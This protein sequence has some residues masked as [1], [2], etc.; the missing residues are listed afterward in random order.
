M[1]QATQ[2]LAERD[3][4]RREG[5]THLRQVLRPRDSDRGDE[6]RRAGQGGYA[7]PGDSVTGPSM[8]IQLNVKGAGPRPPPVRTRSKSCP[9]RDLDRSTTVVGDDF[10]HNLNVDET[11][12]YSFK[13][14]RK[15]RPERPD[16]GLLDPGRFTAKPVTPTCATD[17]SLC[18]KPSNKFVFKGVTLNKKKGTGRIKVK[19]P[20]LGKTTL[21]GPGLNT[22]KATVKKKGQVIGLNLKPK[23][24]SGRP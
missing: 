21:N 14:T 9:G 10:F 8:N 17:P 4:R 2:L 18:P 12:R 23:S 22:A 7:I 5:R 15:P 20:S 16:H 19:F 3:H 6:G 1:V 13:L 11:G 24:S